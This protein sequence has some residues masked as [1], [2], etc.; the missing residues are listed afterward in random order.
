MIQRPIEYMTVAARDSTGGLDYDSDYAIS[1][2]PSDKLLNLQSRYCHCQ[3]LPF[4]QLL[5]TVNVF[6]SR[7]LD[8]RFSY[9]ILPGILTCRRVFHKTEI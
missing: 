5:P 2:L 9:T 3:M 8:Y 1:P 4:K 7:K 6:V